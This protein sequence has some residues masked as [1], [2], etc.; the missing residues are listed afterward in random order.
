MKV[1]CTAFWD[2]ASVRPALRAMRC[3]SGRTN[4]RLTLYLDRVRRVEAA[5]GLR[6]HVLPPHFPRR[7]DGH[8]QGLEPIT[9][10]QADRSTARVSG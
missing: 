7:F 3:N 4:E 9:V 5:T 2:S 6:W 8:D 10:A 1:T